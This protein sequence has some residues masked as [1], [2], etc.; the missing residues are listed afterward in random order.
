MISAGSSL[1]KYKLVIAPALTI[2][3]KEQI[4]TLTEFVKRGGHLVVTARSG[5]KDMD[6]SMET[7]RPPAGLLELTGVVVEE[8]Y[9]LAAPVPIKANYF[10]GNAKI[11]A[12]RLHPLDENSV[13]IARYGVH[14]NGW[15]NNQL[16]M[17]VRPFG[18]GLVYY[19]G[20]WLDDTSQQVFINR[21]LNSA[22]IFSIK[23]PYGVCVSTRQKK[24]GKKVFFVINHTSHVQKFKWPW[25]AHEHL[26]NNEVD[27]TFEMKSYGV[28]ILTQSK[29]PVPPEPEA[30]E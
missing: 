15:L 1:Q 2:L 9:A 28:A 14:S 16:A 4:A 11:W 26:S 3:N 17:T 12:E 7:L 30:T 24:D 6:N 18:K 10:D 5:V 13:P 23:T 20:C 22:L 25:Y 21:L 29:K 27:G 19:V 8:A